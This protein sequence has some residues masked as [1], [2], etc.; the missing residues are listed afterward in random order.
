[1][2]KVLLLEKCWKSLE[3]N[4]FHYEVLIGRKFQNEKNETFLVNVVLKNRFHFQIK[5]KAYLQVKNR[6]QRERALP[7]IKNKSSS[8][9]NN[10]KHNFSFFVLGYLF[11]AALS[12]Q[13]APCRHICHF[14]GDKIFAVAPIER[15]ML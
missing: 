14:C 13:N 2:H 7:E 9:M 4:V 3:T 12:N 11:K 15:N 10:S 1:M 6:D 5:I 8:G